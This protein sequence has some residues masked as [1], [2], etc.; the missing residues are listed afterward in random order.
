MKT[1]TRIMLAAMVL[2]V[3]FMLI[4]VGEEEIFGFIRSSNV[5]N[6]TIAGLV[7]ILLLKLVLGSFV[8]EKK[9]KPESE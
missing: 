8:D 5:F 2:W 3:P 9:A 7:V 4:L 6:Y 1:S